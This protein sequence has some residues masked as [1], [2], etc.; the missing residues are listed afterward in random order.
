MAGAAA[1]YCRI[2]DDR[3]GRALGVQRQEDDCRGLARARGWDVAEVYLDNDFS[4]FSRKLRPAFRRML[5]DLREGHRDGLVFY[6]LDRLVRS[7]RELEDVV[8]VCELAGVT[9]AISLSGDF[10]LTTPDG[11][12]R[13]RIDAAH[14]ARESDDKSRRIRRKH[15]ELAEGGKVS[16]GGTRPYGYTDDRRHVKAS[17]AKVIRECVRRAMAGE[18]LRSVCQSLNDRGITTVTGKNWNP[19]VLRRMLMSARIGGEREHLGVIMAT[20]EWPPIIPPEVAATLRATLAARARGPARSPR[21]YLLTGLLRCSHCGATLVSRPR[22]DGER[23]YVCAKGPGFA[24]CGKTTTLAPP[25]EEYIARGILDRLDSPKLEAIIRGELARDD[26]SAALQADLDRT[27]AKLD[28]L[29]L[30]WSQDKITKR[31]WLVA[32]KPLEAEDERLKRELSRVSRVPVLADLLGNASTL[33]T[34]WPTLDLSR[35]QAIVKA[36]LDHVVV[37]PAVRGRTRFDPS[38]LRPVWRL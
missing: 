33:R 38:R 17:E 35:Q 3:E 11:R 29:S 18:S 23:R 5:D 26:Q 30:L 7:N 27:L 6:H 31:Q 25:V 16:G 2:S 1:V 22:A 21:R 37:G 8:D 9:D 28:E 12:Y 4:A 10:D 36:L 34:Q 24:G 20:A 13:A 15:L 32:N 19:H 14:A